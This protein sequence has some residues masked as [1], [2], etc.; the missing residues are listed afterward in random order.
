M[1]DA[2]VVVRQFLDR[3]GCK[4]GIH[5]LCWRS[6]FGPSSGSWA[7]MCGKRNGVY[8]AIEQR[9]AVPEVTGTYGNPRKDS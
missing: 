1:E 7:C 5:R 2:V 3:A 9:T 6:L 8:K 4:I